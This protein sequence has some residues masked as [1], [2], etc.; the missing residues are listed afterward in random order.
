MFLSLGAVPPRE[1]RR[2]ALSFSIRLFS[3]SCNSW[4]F[5]LIPVN[6]AALSKIFSSRFSV[7]LMHTSLHINVHPSSFYRTISWG[8]QLRAVASNAVS[9]VRKNGEAKICWIFSS[10][11]RFPVSLACIIPSGDKYGS[12]PFQDGSTKSIRFPCRQIQ[13]EWSLKST[14]F[15]MKVNEDEMITWNWAKKLKKSVAKQI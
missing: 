11:R 6:L 14:V 3:P 2:F 1:A 12:E 13:I 4:V 5:S 10:L 7:V 9:T 8:S 15:T